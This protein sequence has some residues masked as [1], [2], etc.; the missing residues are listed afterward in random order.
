MKEKSRLGINSAMLVSV[1]FVLLSGCNK[2]EEVSDATPAQPQTMGSKIDDTTVTAK[3]KAELLKNPDIKSTDIKVETNN[4]EVMLSGFV[5]SQ[6]QLDKSIAAAR[7]V[8]GVKSVNNML[9]LKGA[10]TTTSG[11]IDDTVIT[12]KVKSALLG[13]ED[14]NSMDI[15]VETNKGDVQLTGFVDNE[16]QVARAVEIAKGIEGVGTVRNQLSIKKK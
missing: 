2:S 4:G 7:N 15:S 9:A 16:Q 1:L 8:E 5:E 12:T 13:A 10:S 6:A 11:K 3:V 14:L